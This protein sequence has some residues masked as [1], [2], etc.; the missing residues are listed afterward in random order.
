MPAEQKAR[1]HEL[2]ARLDQLS[3]KYHPGELPQTLSM[4]DL[5]PEA[6]V[7]REACAAQ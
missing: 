3:A 5:G 6:P 2:K 4:A 7:T 1:W